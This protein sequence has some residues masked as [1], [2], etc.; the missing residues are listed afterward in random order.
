MVNAGHVSQFSGICV[1]KIFRAAVLGLNLK[2]L[3]G[4]LHTWGED[5]YPAQVP[6]PFQST[7]CHPI[8]WQGWCFLV[9]SRKSK[10]LSAVAQHLSKYNVDASEATDATWLSF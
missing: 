6:L 2:S 10:A 7:Y 4:P 1:Q 5:Q 8:S 3:A 9:P